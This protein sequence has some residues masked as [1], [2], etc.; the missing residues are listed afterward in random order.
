MKIILFR[1]EKEKVHFLECSINSGNLVLGDKEIISL[2]S[3]RSRGEKYKKILDELQHIQT[4]YSPNIFAYQS[5]PYN[6]SG[7][8]DEVR[9]ANESIMNLFCHENAIEL[10]EFT[11]PLVRKKLSISNKDFLELLENNKNE[12]L[13]QYNIVKSD[14]LLEGLVFLFSLKETF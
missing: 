9:F 11:K 1:F 6:M 2:D 5:A 12:I 3:T 14:K 7:K 4:K 10:T 13:N 8:I